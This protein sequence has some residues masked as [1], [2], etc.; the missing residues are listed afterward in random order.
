MPADLLPLRLVADATPSGE[1]S[2]D[3]LMALAGAGHAQA[4]AALVRRHEPRVR[5]F[6][7]LLLNDPNAARDAT[8]ETFLK[9]W[10]LRQRYR[11]EGKFKQLLLT[12]ARNQCRSM[13]RG[14]L[15]R[16]LLPLEHA[17]AEPAP[18]EQGGSPGESLSEAQRQWLVTSALARL[19]PRFREP[20]A[21]RFL[22]G[23][24]YEEIAQVIGRTP[25]AARS[26]VHYGLRQLADLLPEEL[27]E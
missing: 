21:L 3:A 6:C 11:P 16:L 22:E 9:L 4:Y 15:L 14:R 18:L 24:P 12:T 19:P 23:M 27:F 20:L 7:Q 2:D 26:R 25:S 1:P 10:A 17:A 8:Q 13:Q 5:R